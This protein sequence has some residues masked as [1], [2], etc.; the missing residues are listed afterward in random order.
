MLSR[1]TLCDEEA[2]RCVAIYTFLDAI[3][4]QPSQTNVVH[5]MNQNSQL[6]KMTQMNDTKEHRTVMEGEN[7]DQHRTVM[8]GENN[9]HGEPEDSFSIECP[10]HSK[11]CPDN[12]TCCHNAK[13]GWA[14]CEFRQVNT[15]CIVILKTFPHNFSNPLSCIIQLN[16]CITNELSWHL[17][18]FNLLM[19]ET[20]TCRSR[21]N[22]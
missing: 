9:D 13:S 7:N 14:C 16:W 21:L 20:F 5:N 15:R 22:Y 4:S 11:F 6:T 18:L 19:K 10:D 8:E 1:S 12:F 17:L 3:R 2:H